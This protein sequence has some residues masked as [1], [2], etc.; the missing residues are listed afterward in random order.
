MPRNA[1]RHTRYWWVRQFIN[2]LRRT[3][4]N[5]RDS[6]LAKERDSMLAQVVAQ[7]RQ[8]MYA[9]GVLPINKSGREYFQKADRDHFGE[10]MM[11]LI[12][13]RPAIE[14]Q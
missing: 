6:M 10:A 2:R 5:E 14:Q 12:H 4:D 3:R 7:V 11:E 9:L 8:F 13:R 1:T